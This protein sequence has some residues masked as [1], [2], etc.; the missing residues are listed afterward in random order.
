MGKTATAPT[1]Q[2]YLN[3]PYNVSCFGTKKL[4]YIHVKTQNLIL[5]G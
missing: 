4:I 1:V 3:T 2:C 5:Y